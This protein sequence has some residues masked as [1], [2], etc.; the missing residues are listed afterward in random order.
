M[1][2]RKEKKGIS[3]RV[4]DT[5]NLPATWV[6]KNGGGKWHWRETVSQC[7]RFILCFPNANVWIVN[8]VFLSSSIY[9]CGIVKTHYISETKMFQC[10][11]ATIWCKTNIILCEVSKWDSASFICFCYLLNRNM[12]MFLWDFTFSVCNVQCKCY[13]TE[14]GGRGKKWSISKFY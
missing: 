7:Y 12:S 4:K 13:R 1:R 2:K 14:S 8:S 6:S 3:Q 5:W 10:S 11:T 9:L